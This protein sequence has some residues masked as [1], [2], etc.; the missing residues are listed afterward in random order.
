MDFFTFG[1][2]S[3]M[4]TPR[5]PSLTIV[6]TIFIL[7]SCLIF[8]GCGNLRF[9]PSES[10][11]QL[12]FTTYKN[13][14]EVAKLGAEAA[15]PATR[16][17]VEGTA[18]ALAYTGMPKAPEVEDYPAALEQAQADAVKRP[19]SADVFDAAE[20][21]LSLAAELAILLG[22]GGAGIGGKKVIDWIA[23]ARNKSNALREVVEG[24]ELLKE[25]LKVN[26]KD[27]EL[28]AFK[29]FQ[30]QKQTAD[31]AKLVALE[32]LPIKRT[33]LLKTKDPVVNG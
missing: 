28:D 32:R 12:A 9:G 4:K 20:G 10:Q 3:A 16:Q 27:G 23:L 5:N 29:E 17:I 14:A 13:A 24:N 25:Y 26:G 22:A 21:G 7:L 19:K 8:S 6:L 15:S 2:D 18:A 30:G 1:K 31:T 11:K 33:V